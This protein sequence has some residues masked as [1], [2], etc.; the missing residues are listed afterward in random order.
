M[1]RAGAEA[2]SYMVS[3]FLVANNV[4]LGQL[5][6]DE[7]SNEITTIFELLEF[8]EVKGYLITLDAMGYQR[9]IAQKIIDKGAD[10]LLAVKGNQG[11]LHRAFVEHFPAHILAHWKGDSYMIKEKSHDLEETRLYIVSDLFYEF[12][13]YSFDWKGMKT[14]GIAMS[15]REVKGE[16]PSL[17]NICIRYYISSAELTAEKLVQATRAL[18]FIENKLH[19][20]L[21]IG[22]REDSFRV[23][24]GDAAELLAGFRHIAMNL[25][26]KVI[27][28]KG[29]LKRIQKKASR[30]TRLLSEVLSG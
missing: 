30:N 15:F 9:D 1:T 13:N 3:A 6:T 23:R 14:L 21:D 16:M 19:W 22:M 11:R 17:D 25:L 4:V 12:V 5:K 27:G 2:L 10:Y 7:K 29:S 8:L 20:K 28:F 24:R 26:N 18:W